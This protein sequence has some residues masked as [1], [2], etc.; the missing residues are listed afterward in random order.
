MTRESASLAGV[1][2]RGSVSHNEADTCRKYVV[3]KLQVAGWDTDPHRIQEQVTFTDGRIVVTGTKA[4]RRDGKRAD[5]VLRFTRD[6]ALA[7]VEAKP[8]YKKPADGLQQAKGY[9]EILGLTFADTAIYGVDAS[10]TASTS[11]AARSRAVAASA[12]PSRTATIAL[13]SASE[14]SAYA[15]IT[16]RDLTTFTMFATKVLTPGYFSR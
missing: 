8:S 14:T 9:A 11:R 2:E 5:Y 10:R 4:R 3:P 12:W 7:V 6:R 1:D 16:G 15:G 13:A